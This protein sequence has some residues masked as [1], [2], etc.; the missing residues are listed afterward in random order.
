MVSKV[1]KKHLKKKQKKAFDAL[2]KGDFKKFNRITEEMEAGKRTMDKQFMEKGAEF[3][4]KRRK[5]KKELERIREESPQVPESAEEQKKMSG[6]EAREK[7]A[8]KEQKE[9]ERKRELREKIE[10][11]LEEKEIE[12]DIEGTYGKGSFDTYKDAYVRNYE[13]FR[14][15]GASESLA[16]ISAHEEAIRKLRRKQKEETKKDKELWG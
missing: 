9:K 8:E 15:E 5:L 12:S 7:E 2:E 11:K 14:E 4:A 3:L 1:R 13:K 16:G 10:G 6:R